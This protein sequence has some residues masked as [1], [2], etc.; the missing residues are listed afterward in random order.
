M[1]RTLRRVPRWLVDV[2]RWLVVRPWRVWFSLFL[3]IAALALA[4]A[5]SGNWEQRFRLTGWLLQ[6][7]GL[8]TVAVGL[9]ETRKLFRRP[10][11]LDLAR[12]W[13]HGFP[14]LSPRSYVLNAEPGSFKITGYA[15]TIFVSAR[16]EDLT[17]EQRIAR[18][19]QALTEVKN[20]M[21]EVSAK[22]QREQQVRTEAIHSERRAR[23]TSDNTLAN[24]LE[25][26]MAG[27]LH[28]EAMG[29]FWIIVGVSFATVSIELSK[30]F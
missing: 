3:V 6:L 27:G 26:A 24:Q 20:Q 16:P 22:L 1:P 9:R 19:E 29:L 5:I 21:D 30:L 14:S 17:V 4:A 10:S 18:L 12:A 11:L 25:E 2:A 28:L 13:I 8:T 15:P 23:E 7:V